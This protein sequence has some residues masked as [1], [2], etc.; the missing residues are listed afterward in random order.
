[1]SNQPFNA[2]QHPRAGDG[3]FTATTH[4]DAIPALG[5]QARRPELEGWPESLPEP[6]LEI[7]VGEG[8]TISTTVKVNGEEVFDIWNP[9][10]D[11]H[12]TVS[13]DFVTSAVPD[14]VHDEAKAWAF[15][16]HNEIAD[17]IREE[18]RAAFERSRAGILAKVTGAPA[19]Q[20]S[21]EEL[22]TLVGLNQ[23]AAYRGRRDAEMASVAVIAR[24]I[25]KDHPDA[26]HIG[27]QVDSADNGEFVSGAVI[28]DADGHSMN[29]ISSYDS[30]LGADEEYAGEGV[31]ELFSGLEAEPS[32]A[33]WA[34][35]NIPVRDDKDRFTIDLQKAAAWTPGAA[36]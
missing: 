30:Y 35:F 14:D 15:T 21:D 33:H 25:L 7:H 23:E 4:S 31:A 24:S 6:E 16:K 32:N 5:V 27:L 22:G 26:H 17:A 2:A 12:D 13:D 11:I 10:D 29:S 1:M 19:P 34:D 9:A 28:Y 18:Q 20:L 8:G 3:T 36:A